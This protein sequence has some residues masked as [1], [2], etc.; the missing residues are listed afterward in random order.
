MPI[1]FPAP[2]AGVILDMDGLLL[3]TELVYRKAFIAAAAR[4]GFD[5]S[6]DLYQGMVGLADNVGR[7][8]RWSSRDFSKAAFVS[9]CEWHKPISDHLRK[10]RPSHRRK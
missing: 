2:V 5:M 10:P 7:V 3:D 6:E 4:L 8:P 1:V 9:H